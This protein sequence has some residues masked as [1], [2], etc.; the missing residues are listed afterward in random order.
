VA[1]GFEFTAGNGL[2][3]VDDDGGVVFGKSGGDEGV[4]VGFGCQVGVSDGGS[5]KA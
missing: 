2:V 1:G 3:G 4:P 5:A